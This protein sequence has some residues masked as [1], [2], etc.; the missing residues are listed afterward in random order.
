[1]TYG[2]GY[3]TDCD[4]DTSWVETVENMT[5]GNATLSVVDGDWFKIEAVFDDGETDEY[6]YY[7]YDITNVSTTVYPKA[8]VRWKTSDA[9]EVIA[10]VHFDYTSGTDLTYNL[11]SSTDVTW[12]AIDLPTGKTIDKVRFYADDNGVDGTYYVYYDFLLIHK[13]TFTLPFFHDAELEMQ[14]RDADLPIPGRVGSHTQYLGMDSPI[15]RVTGE[16][17]TNTDWGTPDGQ[18]LYQIYL[19]R[20]NDPWQWFTSDL[21]NCKVTPR[22]FN[23]SQRSDTATQRVWTADFKH[24]SL[25][26]GDTSEWSDLEWLGV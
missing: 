2:H 4:D 22:K 20:H 8:L 24:Y 5:A 23:I 1:M 25:S 14:N 21:V 13:G 26:G 19:E 6:C 12:T 17:D 9:S 18:R 7:E 3:L 16:M 15:I 11:G 10:K